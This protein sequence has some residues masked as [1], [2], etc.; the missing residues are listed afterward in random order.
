MQRPEERIQA[1][2]IKKIQENEEKL[3]ALEWRRDEIEKK[4]DAIFAIERKFDLYLRRQEEAYAVDP[5]GTAELHNFKEEMFDEQR[6]TKRLLD[7]ERDALEGERKRLYREQED[8]ED[9]RRLALNALKKDD[10]RV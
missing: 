1:E 10:K 2:Y 5:R 8:F 6:C 7:D 9:Q 3:L 4:E